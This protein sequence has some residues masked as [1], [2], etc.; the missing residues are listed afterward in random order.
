MK[1]REEFITYLKQHPFFPLFIQEL[2]KRRPGVPAYDPAAD[3]TEVWKSNSA[4][5]KGFD[6]ACSVFNITLE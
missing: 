6:L 3:N 5:V 4:Q 1:N 2:K